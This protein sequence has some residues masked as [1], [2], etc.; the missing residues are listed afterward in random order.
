MMLKYKSK[1]KVTL[2]K[3]STTALFFLLPSIA[4]VGY[5]VYVSIGWNVIVSLSAWLELE[6]NYRIVGFSNYAYEFSQQS[7]W[8]SLQN[9]LLLILL[10]VPSSLLLGLFLAILLDNKAR[11]EGVF[12]TVYLLPFSLSFVITASLWYWMYNFGPPSGVINSLLVQIGLGFLKSGWTINPSLALY[13]VIMALVWQ[14][15]GY[16]MLIFLAGIRSI[17]ESQVMAAE[18]DG[19]SGFR[20]YTRIIIPQLKSSALA[21]FVILMVFALKAFDFIF[22]LTG[23]GPA[24][25]STSVLALLM[26]KETFG[27][28]FFAYG[29]AVATVLLILVMII[30]IPYLYLSFRRREG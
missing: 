28:D 1:M 7:F 23:G 16:T 9:N 30:V 19:A 5:F 14:F 20:L 10:F 15:S 21:T 11:G 6:P 27:Q 3:E 2:L 8:I 24:G 29:A 26:Y 22:V 12:R 4:L 13:A 25:L 17:P 18:V